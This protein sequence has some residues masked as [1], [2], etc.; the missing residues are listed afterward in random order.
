MDKLSVALTTYNGEKY[1]KDQLNSIL[2]Q[3]LPVQ[4]IVICDDCSTD[5]TLE[6]IEQIKEKNNTNTEIKIVKNNTNLGY[7]NNFYQAIQFT[8]GDY[9]FLSDQDDIWHINKVETMMSVMKQKNITALCTNF[10]L[11]NKHGEII[12]DRSNYRINPFIKRVRSQLTPITFN[13]LVFGNVSQGCTYC[14]TKQVKDA[15]IKIHSSHLIHDHQIMFIAS[16]L[17]NVYFLDEKLIDY[18]IHGSNAIGFKKKGKS[19]TIK[20][21]KPSKKPF[22]VQFFDDVDKVIAIPLKRFYSILYY[23]RIPYLVSK[24]VRFF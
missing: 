16:L 4:E 22:M 3:S 11:I 6:I 9:V 19:D 18:R 1:I 8:H 13:T 7:I 17:G 21:K 2:H 15:Y 5:R 20:I 14:F 10:T 23:L 24:I 12:Q